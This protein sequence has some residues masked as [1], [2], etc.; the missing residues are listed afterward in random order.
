MLR[1]RL[2]LAPVLV[3][4]A[5]FL[6]NST[7]GYANLNYTKAEKKPCVTCHVS[8]KS[9]ELNAVGKCYKQ[10]RTLVGCESKS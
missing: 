8:I 5:G 9:K 3:A 1:L 7:L 2:V 6:L 4:G 10:K